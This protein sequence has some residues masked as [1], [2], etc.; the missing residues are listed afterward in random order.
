M[1]S[2]FVVAS[3]KDL[4]LAKEASADAARVLPMRNAVHGRMRDT[5]QA[6]LGDCDWSAMAKFPSDHV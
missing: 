3:F 4:C 6:G 2:V 5:V 1:L